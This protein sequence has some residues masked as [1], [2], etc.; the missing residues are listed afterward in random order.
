MFYGVPLLLVAAQA[1]TMWFW[2]LDGRHE[3]MR[4]EIDR[5]ESSAGTNVE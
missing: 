2:N 3:E 1:V 4:A 5:R